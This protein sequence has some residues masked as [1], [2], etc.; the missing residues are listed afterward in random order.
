MMNTLYFIT[1]NETID[2]EI[3]SRLLALV[4]SKRQEQICNI[5][6]DI[7]KN[8]SL[9]SELI[10]R[11]LICQTT[12]LDNDHINFT[13]NQYGKPYLIGHPNFHFN[14]SHERFYNIWTKKDSYVK[15]IG[16]GLTI[17]LNSFDVLSGELKCLIK[18]INKE[19]YII[20][21]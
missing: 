2:T 1:I 5:R 21:S 16:K 20:S 8:L 4:S 19:G 14:I 9:F 6:F 12:Y 15:Y 17:P 13:R 7:D 10:V 18:T 3:F 11:V